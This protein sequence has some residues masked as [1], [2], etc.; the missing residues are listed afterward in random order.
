ML[1]Q[2]FRI[3]ILFFALLLTGINSGSLFTVYFSN[4]NTAVNTTVFVE[5][6]ADLF[7]ETSDYRFAFGKEENTV[8]VGFNSKEDVKK[9]FSFSSFA[10]TGQN[11][12]NYFRTFSLKRILGFHFPF[13]ILFHR[14]LL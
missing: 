9:Q 4:E 7:V 8:P 11:V 6:N 13:F 14:L 10:T 5:K 3:L 12:K 1:K 2:S